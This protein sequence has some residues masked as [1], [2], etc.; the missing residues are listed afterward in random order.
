MNTPPQPMPPLHRFPRMM[1]EY[2]NKRLREGYLANHA[3]VM[4]L[5]TRAEAEEYCAEVRQKIA[6]VFGPW[7]EKTPLNLRVTGEVDRGAY[8]IRKLIFESRPHVSMSANLYLPQGHAGARPAVLCPCGHNWRAKTFDM[9]QAFLQSLARM[10]YIVLI[11]DP[12][13]Q[14]ERVQFPDGHGE[15]LFGPGPSYPSVREH[16]ALGIQTALTGDWI[17]K[18]FAWDGMRALDVL[19]AQE[20]VDP[21]RVGVTGVSGGGTIATYLVACDARITM[22]SPCCAVS[23]WY[24]CGS[25]ELPIDAEQCPPGALAL[26]LEQSDLLLAHAPMPVLLVTEEQDFFD[27]RGA[28]EAFDRLRRVYQ[29]LG[30]ENNL[31]YYVGP[32]VH[33]YWQGGREAMY[34]FFSR[35]AAVEASA[36]E[37]M[38]TLEDP[39]ILRCSVTG[40][41]SDLPD[42]CC[43]PDIIRQRARELA[44]ERGVPVGAELRQRLREL[45]RLPRRDGPPDYRI[46][47]PWSARGYA[48]PYANQFVLETDKAYGAQAIVTKLEDE[49]RSARPMRGDGPAM[50][51]LPHLSSDE[52]MRA[53]ALLRTLTTENPAFF[54]CDYR[55][56]GESRPNTCNPDSFFD[57]Y[58]SDYH[59]ASYTIMLGESVVAWRAHDVLCTLDWMESF[60]YDQVH[61]VAQGWG[62]VTGAMAALLDDRVQRVTLIHPITSFTEVLNAPMPSCP[63]SGILPGILQQLDLPDIFQ[64]LAGKHLRVIEP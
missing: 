9:H 6:R 12:M 23:S 62:T 18:W 50:L 42:A 2:L 29:L 56:I 24:H 1:Q 63:L 33:G 44:S 16:N 10:G 59:Y 25:N 52:E 35:H 15:S 61:L 5:T 60:G 30:A 45:L 28:L 43:L 36:R 32:S 58:G 53:D 14:G 49:P 48:R 21:A 17:G 39:D 13:G 11:F 27:Q 51:Y 4:G 26:G 8:L 31:D 55:G 34:A 7:P 57:G 47:R 64:A 20:G 19:L 41:V 38:V 37:P 46:L 40:Q 54:A 3:G 22:A